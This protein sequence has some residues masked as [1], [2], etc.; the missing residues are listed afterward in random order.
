M[1]LLTNKLKV[2]GQLYKS[3]L[4][5]ITRLKMETISQLRNRMIQQRMMEEFD[6]AGKEDMIQRLTMAFQ[7]C[8]SERL[9][10]VLW[11]F[12]SNAN[13]A[14]L[15]KRVLLKLLEST[16]GQAFVGFQKWKSVPD[17]SKNKINKNGTT[18]YSNLI[19][20]LQLRLR[21]PM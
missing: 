17:Q 1:L 18:F 4:N 21:L 10:L 9:R 5:V 16:C 14:D 11:C 2:V 7:K 3:C 8:K 6:K 15:V 13:N 12:A 19:K 20:M